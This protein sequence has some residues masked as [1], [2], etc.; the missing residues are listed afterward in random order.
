MATKLK[1]PRCGKDVEHLCSYCWRCKDCK[2]DCFKHME[3]VVNTTVG[4]S[5]KK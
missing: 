2:L 3:R 1:C 4:K 5:S